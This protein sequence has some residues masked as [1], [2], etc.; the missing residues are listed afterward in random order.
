MRHFH[1]YTHTR[2]QGFESGVLSCTLCN[3]N[4][5]TPKKPQ[6]PTIS[7][8]VCAHISCISKISTYEW[9]VQLGV[10]KLAKWADENDFK[11][12]PLK[13]TGVL[14]SRQRGIRP[15]TGIVLNGAA[16]PVN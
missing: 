6:P 4:T 7:C 3:I 11:V 15:D 5:N 13:R 8:S 10:N 16:V 14:F 12:N 2:K 9:Q 1:N